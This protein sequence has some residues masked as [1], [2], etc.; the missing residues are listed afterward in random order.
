MI[1]PETQLRFISPDIGYGVFATAP[2]PKGTMVY[3]KDELEITI[4]PDSPLLQRPEYHKVITKYSY[5]ENGLYIISWDIEKYVNHSCE[6][7]TLST[8]YGFEIAVRDIEPEEE[9]RDDYGMFNLDYEFE[10][11]CGSPRC[12]G[13]IAQRNSADH[14]DWW[15]TR[16]KAA[17]AQF[18]AVKQPLMPYLDDETHKDVMTYLETGQGYQSIDALR[19]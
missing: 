16:L 5:I 8:G 6:S 19:E 11:S 18:K 7:N 10:C 2:I 3:V 4:P 17:L 13:T 15:D 14:V 9:L 12:R 1:H